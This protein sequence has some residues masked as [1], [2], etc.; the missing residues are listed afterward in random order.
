[1]KPFLRWVGGKRQLL[2]E[3]LKRLP[4]YVGTYHEP[5]VGGGALF[6][7]TFVPG[8]GTLLSDTNENVI[9]AYK[10]VRDYPEQTIAILKETYVKGHNERGAEFYK[11]IRQMSRDTLSLPGQAAWTIFMNQT[12]FNGLWRVNKSGGFNVPYGKRK[13]PP[14]CNEEN[15]RSCSKMLED[16]ALIAGD[17][18]TGLVECNDLVYFDPPYVPVKADSFTA[19]SAKGFGPNEQIRLRDYAEACSRRGAHV[20]LSN[21]GAPWVRELYKG[22]RIDEVQARRNVNSDGAGRG[23]VAEV[24]ISN[25]E[26]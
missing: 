6:W 24:I 14:I 19:Y 25:R 2:P 23:P 4:L 20:I 5:F 21:S 13:N 8:R 7:A 3:L 15:L 18:D 10:G 16:A 17:F 9:A 26:E 22:W 11:E 12:C 1:M